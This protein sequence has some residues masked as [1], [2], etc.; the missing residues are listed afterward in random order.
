MLQEVHGS[1]VVIKNCFFPFER[2]WSVMVFAAPMRG[3]G[4]VVTLV[5]KTSVPLGMA[6]VRMVFV[7]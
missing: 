6:L 4:G 7:P 1:E 3:K 5:R 2:E